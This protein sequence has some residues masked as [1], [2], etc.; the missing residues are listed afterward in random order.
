[1]S[2]QIWEVVG[3]VDKGGI[4]VR[5][6]KDIA[7]AAETDRLST[8]A[9]VKQLSLDNDRLNYELLTG[10]GPKVGWVSTSLKG[11]DLL[12]KSDKKSPDTASTPDGGTPATEGNVS[13]NSKIEIF[14]GFP[15]NEPPLDGESDANA[16]FVHRADDDPLKDWIPLRQLT[17][18]GKRTPVICLGPPSASAADWTAPDPFGSWDGSEKLGNQLAHLARF[19][20]HELLIAQSPTGMSKLTLDTWAAKLAPRLLGRLEGT[21][22]MG[23]GVSVGCWLLLAFLKALERLGAD[24][25]QAVQKCMVLHMVGFPPPTSGLNFSRPTGMQDIDWTLAGTLSG[26]QKVTVPNKVTVYHL[27]GDNALSKDRVFEWFSLEEQDGS[28]KSAYPFYGLQADHSILQQPRHRADFFWSMSTGN[29]LAPLTIEFGIALTL[30]DYQTAAVALGHG[31]VS[32]GLI[33]GDTDLVFLAFE[34][35]PH[36]K[37]IPNVN[38]MNAKAYSQSNW[39]AGPT[40]FSIGLDIRMWWDTSIQPE[41]GS[42]VGKRIVCAVR[43]G[44]PPCIQIAKGAISGIHGGAIQSVMDEITAQCVRINAVP[45]CTTRNIMHQI[46][47]PAFAYQTYSAECIIESV[48]NDKCVF[49]SKA[50]L[51]D[52]LGKAVCISKSDMVDLARMAQLQQMS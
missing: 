41:E 52:P 5:Q 7:S 16:G 45:G 2:E 21:A 20:N 44:N 15:D 43:F 3:G 40:A 13:L 34:N 22:W 24:G 38:K 46:S 36:L 26:P 28:T 49:V 10:T 14:D 39:T 9:L 27:L 12:V 18:P 47:G 19:N 23:V 30:E 37:R 33:D 29:G 51:K 35:E 42:V 17:P 25:R 8:G 1:M 50:T 48:K 4:L 32:T 6:G 31:D 11:K